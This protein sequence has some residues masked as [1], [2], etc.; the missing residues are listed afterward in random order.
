MEKMENANKIF[1]GK[2]E[3]KRQS[4]RPRGRWDGNIKINI[5]E[6]ECEDVN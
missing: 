4:G 5:K 6:T 3:G 2:P 1:V